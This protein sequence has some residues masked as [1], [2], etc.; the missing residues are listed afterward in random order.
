[1]IKEQADKYID[2]MDEYYHKD[3]ANVMVPFIQAQ[4]YVMCGM[5]TLGY[6]GAKEPSCF[7]IEPGVKGLPYNQSE[8]KFV[9]K[10]LAK[11]IVIAELE[12]PLEYNT[13]N[14]IGVGIP[15]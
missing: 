9:A 1:M 6:I 11:L 3:A 10:V 8:I 2:K 5:G 12:E 13:F 15:C 7:Y 14:H 4:L